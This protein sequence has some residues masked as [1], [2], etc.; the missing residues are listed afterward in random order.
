MFLCTKSGLLVFLKKRVGRLDLILMFYFDS[1]I[2]N[3]FMFDENIKRTIANEPLANSFPQEPLWFLFSST[4]DPEQITKG[5]LLC[6]I[7]V[8]GL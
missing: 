5:W 8:N 3:F 1:N 7:S 6:H 4:S 2:A